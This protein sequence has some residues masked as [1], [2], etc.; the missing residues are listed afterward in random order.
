MTSNV[1]NYFPHP[2]EE[3]QT[4]EGKERVER[5]IAVFEKYVAKKKDEYDYFMANKRSI[6]ADRMMPRWAPASTHGTDFAAFVSDPNYLF[7]KS[8][9]PL[10]TKPL[11]TDAFRRTTRAGEQFKQEVSSII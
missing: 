9:D 4:Q 10:D 1:G 11:Q 2:S 6:F 8:L 5:N 7:R 3:L